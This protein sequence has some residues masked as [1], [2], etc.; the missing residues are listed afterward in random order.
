[1]YTQRGR[2]DRQVIS[3]FTQTSRGLELLPRP[4]YQFIS[5]LRTEDGDTLRGYVYS[6]SPDLLNLR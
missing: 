1:M 3:D 4:V 6:L 5:L 2:T